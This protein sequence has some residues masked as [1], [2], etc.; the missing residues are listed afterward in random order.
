MLFCLLRRRRSKAAYGKNGIR[1][2]SGGGIQPQN[3]EN[4][5]FT[6]LYGLIN[7][8]EKEPQ[9]KTGDMGHQFSP[10]GRQTNRSNRGKV[11]PTTRGNRYVQLIIQVKILISCTLHARNKFDNRQLLL[12]LPPKMVRNL[13]LQIVLHPKK[14]TGHRDNGT[15][16]QRGG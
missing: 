4:P 1:R 13:W 8:R 14:V 16:G 15:A 11:P 6:A 5:S 3:G 2:A 12:T 7:R 9:D 10:D